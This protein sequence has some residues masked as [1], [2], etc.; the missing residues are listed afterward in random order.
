LEQDYFLTKFKVLLRDICLFF[1]KT[2]EKNKKKMGEKNEMENEKRV[3]ES[4]LSSLMSITI[5]L[6]DELNSLINSH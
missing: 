5:R 3:V 2:R 6:E 1:T 4:E